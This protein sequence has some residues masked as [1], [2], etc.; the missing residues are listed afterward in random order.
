MQHKPEQTGHKAWM[1]EWNY[2]IFLSQP[3]PRAPNGFTLSYHFASKASHNEIL[4]APYVNPLI[5]V[6]AGWN[7]YSSHYSGTKTPNKHYSISSVLPSLFYWEESEWLF[8][9]AMCV[10]A[11]EHRNRLDPGS[12]YPSTLS[13]ERGSSLRPLH[14]Q[15][16]LPSALSLHLAIHSVDSQRL[17]PDHRV[18]Y[19]LSVRCELVSSLS[20]CLRFC[21]PQH[22][23]V[24][25]ITI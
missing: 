17:H 10:S 14:L 6:R 19:P 23:V 12:F 22:P 4:A 1:R 15:W 3:A 18:S 16:L 13:L 7:L 25:S 5:T 2:F 11:G 9:Q 8:Q 24:M 20:T 21:P